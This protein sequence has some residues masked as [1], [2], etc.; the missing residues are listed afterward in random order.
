M[1][2]TTS[3]NTKSLKN[4]NTGDVRKALKVKI[5]QLRADELQKNMDKAMNDIEHMTREYSMLMVELQE[6]KGVSESQNKKHIE[7][8]SRMMG[9]QG[10]APVDYDACNTSEEMLQLVMGELDQVKKLET[11][12]K[13]Q[14][15]HALP[16]VGDNSEIWDRIARAQKAV[17]EEEEKNK[18]FMSTDSPL[19]VL[20]EEPV[21]TVSPTR[22]HTPT[23]DFG[24]DSDTLSVGDSGD[25]SDIDAMFKSIV[26]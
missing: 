6:I 11:K 3:D 5:L 13:E 8:L 22:P 18:V 23:T 25:S 15:D 1:D 24:S 14:E 4:E 26:V 12:M 7:L 10:A 2:S 16:D 17:K 9:E 19:A 20:S 21:E